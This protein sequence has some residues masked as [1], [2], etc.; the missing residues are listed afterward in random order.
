[1]CERWVGKRPSGRIQGRFAGADIL[2][3]ATERYLGSCVEMK[4]L[5]RGAWCFGRAEADTSHILVHEWKRQGRVRH[6]VAL[7]DMRLTQYFKQHDITCASSD[8]LE[9]AIACLFHSFCTSHGVKDEILV[10]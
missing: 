10:G 2:A 4:Q 9:I 5:Q 6:R 8:I 1:M 3:M 7:N